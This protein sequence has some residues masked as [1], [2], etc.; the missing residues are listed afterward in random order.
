MVDFAW[1]W[2][3]A[4]ATDEALFI[5][6]YL[7]FVAVY[8]C[9]GGT[10]AWVDLYQPRFW[11][12]HVRKFQ[13][14]KARLA[15]PKQSRTSF[16]KHC[17]VAASRCEHA[18]QSCQERW[19]CARIHLPHRLR[20]LLAHREM[21]HIVLRRVAQH[22]HCLGARSA[23]VLCLHPLPARSAD[24]SR[25]ALKPSMLSKPALCRGRSFSTRL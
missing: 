24:R 22:C 15:C 14:D 23:A 2:L 9:V 4:R 6:G 25:H 17:S 1:R 12:A 21:A 16:R 5:L 10:L 19:V 3:R 11:R 7:L 13:A 20:L 18:A 8:W